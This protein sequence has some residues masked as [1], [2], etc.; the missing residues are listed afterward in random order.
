LTISS[1]DKEHIHKFAKTL[2]YPPCVVKT[3]VWKTSYSKTPKVRLLISKARMYRALQRLGFTSK[4]SE[5]MTPTEIPVDMFRYVLHGIFDGDGSISTYK[6]RQDKRRT[7]LGRTVSQFR[8]CVSQ[9]IMNWIIT[10]LRTIGFNYPICTFEDRNTW[11][12]VCSSSRAIIELYNILY[13]NSN[14]YLERKKESFNLARTIAVAKLRNKAGKS[15]I[16][17]QRVTSPGIQL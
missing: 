12:M 11:V 1:K 2:G 15:L 9:G 17:R 14:V 13:N 4:K 10:S 5:R 6:K 3:Y 7:D 16:K 8:I